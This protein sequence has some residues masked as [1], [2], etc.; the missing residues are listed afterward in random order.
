MGPLPKT[1]K[2]NQYIIVATN[3]S[4]KW[5]EAAA[6]K[7]NTQEVAVDFLYNEVVC[8]Y[9]I[10][11]EVVMDQGSHFIDGLVTN[12]LDKLSVK[13][14]RATPNYPHSNRKLKKLMVFL[15]ASFPK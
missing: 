11:L 2:N 4:T 1:K 10:P 7:R 3:Y 6:T 8:R 12:L 9:G 5:S 13:H 14:R 15:L